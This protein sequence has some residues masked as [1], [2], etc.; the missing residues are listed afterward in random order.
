MAL[1]RRSGNYDGLSNQ[2][3]ID[4]AVLYFIEKELEVIKDNF[5]KNFSEEIVS[6]QDQDLKKILQTLE[7]NFDDQLTIA[8]NDVYEGFHSNYLTHDFYSEVQDFWGRGEGYLDRV[9]NSYEKK[10]K[11]LF[12]NLIDHIQKETN[13][14]FS[15]LKYKG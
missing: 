14:I 3:S 6:I 15:L 11:S 10:L 7:D 2:A 8:V 1:N 5:F 9:R 4:F 13:N 12:E